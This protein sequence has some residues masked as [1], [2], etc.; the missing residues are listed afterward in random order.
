MSHVYI[1]VEE[2]KNFLSGVRELIGF[3]KR[4]TGGTGG[5]DRADG[6]V[7]LEVTRR[8]SAYVSPSNSVE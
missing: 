7:Y 5:T 6:A 1:I 3:D 4:G 2:S 8:L